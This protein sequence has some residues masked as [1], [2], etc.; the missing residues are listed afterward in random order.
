MNKIQTAHAE[1]I[2]KIRNKKRVPLLRVIR[3][4]CADCTCWQ[5]AE[6][7]LCEIKNCILWD[8]RMGKNPIK[9]VMSEKQ[10]ANLKKMLSKS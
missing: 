9:R 3:L 8:F 1:A 5:E 2:K 10:K 7:R 4:K 6:I